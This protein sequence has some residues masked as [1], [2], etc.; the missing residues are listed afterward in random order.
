M[1]PDV[2]LGLRAASSGGYP[3][4]TASPQ[5]LFI[6]GQ[7]P[8]KPDI[9]SRFQTPGRSSKPLFV[10]EVT[11]TGTLALELLFFPV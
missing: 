10:H 2:M 5:S 8:V 9:P 11:I 1:I 6:R 4:R 3:R 7:L